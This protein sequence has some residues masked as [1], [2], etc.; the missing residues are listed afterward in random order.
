MSPGA[1]QGGMM[2]ALLNARALELRDRPEHAG[3]EATGGR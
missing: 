2:N 1:S 3:D